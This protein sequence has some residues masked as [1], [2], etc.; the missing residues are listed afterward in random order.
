MV[1]VQAGVHGSARHILRHILLTGDIWNTILVD[2]GICSVGVT[3]VA[4]TS[5]TTVNQ[6]LDGRDNITNSTIGSNL[7]NKFETKCKLKTKLN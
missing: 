2:P 3:T 6:H 4:I 1:A 5:I 7:H